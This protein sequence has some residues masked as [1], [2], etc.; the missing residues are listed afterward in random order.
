MKRG[1]L[2]DL[3]APG[4][5]ATDDGYLSLLVVTLIAGLAYLVG[6]IVGRIRGVQRRR[7]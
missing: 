2:D 5:A 7:N 4:A 1:V 6:V 3:A